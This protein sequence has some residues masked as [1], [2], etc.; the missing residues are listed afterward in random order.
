M[1]FERSYQLRILA[2]QFS[3]KPRNFS[4]SFKPNNSVNSKLNPWFITGFTDAEG[5]F[6]ITII[7]NDQSKLK[8]RVIPSFAIHIHNKDIRLL[9]QILATRKKH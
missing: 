4:T 7:K 8:W 6:M 5:S 9:N 3:N 2:K 1:G